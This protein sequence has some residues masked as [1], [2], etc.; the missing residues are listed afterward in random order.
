MIVVGLIL[1]IFMI[2]SAVSGNNKYIFDEYDNED[3]RSS[4]IKEYKTLG[5][6][7]KEPLDNIEKIE[8]KQTN[9]MDDKQT[10]QLLPGFSI[11]QIII[12]NDEADWLDDVD[13]R[14]E[15]LKD[16][17]KFVSNSP[18]GNIYSNENIWFD[19]DEI[20]DF[21]VRFRIRN[22]WIGDINTGDTNGDIQFLKWTGIDW[23]PLEAKIIEKDDIYTYYELTTTGSSIFSIGK[24]TTT[25]KII[26]NV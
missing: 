5:I 3:L 17:S 7:I 8:I 2:Q 4:D 16:T 25:K 11:Y 15:H 13:I 24:F 9:L 10:I 26:M 21:L 12:E 18:S 23:K 14:I 19:S 22:S 1:S 6:T 20:G